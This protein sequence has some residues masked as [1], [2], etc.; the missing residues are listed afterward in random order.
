[1]AQLPADFVR[2]CEKYAKDAP[3]VMARNAL[4]INGFA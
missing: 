4:A 3:A 1:M 2:V